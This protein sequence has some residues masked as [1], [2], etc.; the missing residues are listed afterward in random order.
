MQR[1]LSV[2]DFDGLMVILLIPGSL[3]PRPVRLPHVPPGGQFEGHPSHNAPGPSFPLLRLPDEPRIFSHI[4]DS[5]GR[6]A[7]ESLACYTFRIRSHLRF[8]RRVLFAI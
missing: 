3:G 1:I 5:R 2:L 7:E 6:V 8:I 4:Q